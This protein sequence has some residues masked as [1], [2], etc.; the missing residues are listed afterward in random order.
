MPLIVQDGKLITK[1]GHLA[2]N[3]GC[4]CL[5]SLDCCYPNQPI[6]PP[7]EISVSF[8]WSN[9]GISNFFFTPLAECLLNTI[10]G[11][12][13]LK[14]VNY[15]NSATV[16]VYE[17]TAPTGL[18]IIYRWACS[19]FF[20]LTTE[21]KYTGCPSPFPFCFNYSLNNI[22]GQALR[23]EGL[24]SASL[25]GFS[26]TYTITE[27]YSEKLFFTENCVAIQPG[28]VQ[29]VFDAVWSMSPL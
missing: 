18:R 21:W 1:N 23:H 16:V 14:P 26:T 17:V 2:G 20:R 10:I 28:Q 25:H 8:T 29:M 5:P 9:L 24:C 3:L 11:T 22:P 12:Y 19:G 15:P 7:P 4:C 27:T 6:R 13:V